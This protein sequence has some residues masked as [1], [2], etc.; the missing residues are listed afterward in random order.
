MCVVFGLCVDGN[1]HPAE[2]HSREGVR[3]HP[4]TLAGK[5]NVAAQG[6]VLLSASWGSTFRGLRRRR[7][8]L[9]LLRR[10]ACDGS[11]EATRPCKCLIFCQEHR[12]LGKGFRRVVRDAE[13]GG[14]TGTVNCAFLERFPRLQF[15]GQEWRGQQGVSVDTS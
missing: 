13:E 1:L 12:D 4:G 7:A 11:G 9:H 15:G 5:E 3:V 14:G 6:S 2:E 10:M 8:G